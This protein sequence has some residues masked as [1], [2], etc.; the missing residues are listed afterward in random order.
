MKVVNSV[1]LALVATWLIL[2][3]RPLEDRGIDAEHLEA[4]AERVRRPRGNETTPP[5]VQR[6]KNERRRSSATFAPP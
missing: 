1:L 5:A 6:R 2:G 4:L 3:L